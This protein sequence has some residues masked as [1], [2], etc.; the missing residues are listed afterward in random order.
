MAVKN[1]ESLVQCVV[2]VANAA[3]AKRIGCSQATGRTPAI[4]SSICDPAPRYPEPF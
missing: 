3:N 1:L 4:L 2:V